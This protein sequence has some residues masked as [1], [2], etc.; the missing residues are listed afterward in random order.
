MRNGSFESG[1]EL[2]TSPQDR[3]SSAGRAQQL[4]LRGQVAVCHRGQQVQPEREAKEE[5]GGGAEVV[6][7]HVEVGQLAEVLGCS[8]TKKK[9]GVSVCFIDLKKIK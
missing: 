6:D 1:R 4:G 5:R 3:S 2:E 8:N 9:R 7:N